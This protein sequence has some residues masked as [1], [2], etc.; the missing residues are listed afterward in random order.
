[1][2]VGSGEGVRYEVWGEGLWLL[3]GPSPAAH[4]PPHPVG[5]L[6]SWR[7]MATLRSLARRPPPPPPWS[8]MEQARYGYLTL[9]L[10]PPPHKYFCLQAFV[11]VYKI[12]MHNF[13]EI[14]VDF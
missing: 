1:M 5:Q 2:G 8:V 4:P 10:S 3:N 9:P 12:K 7:V 11:Q 13:Y 6:W 14:K